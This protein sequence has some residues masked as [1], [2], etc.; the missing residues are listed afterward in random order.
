MNR[1][2]N[3]DEARHHAGDCFFLFDFRTRRVFEKWFHRIG[4][5]V[6]CWFAGL[7]YPIFHII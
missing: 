6:I 4:R 2:N 5:I 7:S 3:L 1:F